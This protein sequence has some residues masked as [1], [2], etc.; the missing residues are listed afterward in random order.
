MDFVLYEKPYTRLVKLKTSADE[1]LVR[2]ENIQLLHEPFEQIFQFQ[3][4]R[5]FLLPTVSTVR[6]ED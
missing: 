1:I 2:V 3:S 4:L 6:E 5:H